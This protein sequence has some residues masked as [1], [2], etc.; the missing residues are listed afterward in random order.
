MLSMVAAASAQHVDDRPLGTNAQ[1]RGEILFENRCARCH[2][3]KGD[4]EGGL[5]PSLIGVIGKPVASRTD[6]IY[7]DALKA[8][9]R[10][11][12]PKVLDDYLADPQAFA[13]GAD[14]DI[15]SP[16]PAERAAIIEFVGTL[17]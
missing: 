8:K 1:P 7:S 15:R 11:W 13:P 12:A 5:G 4:G 14:M 6:F 17:R 9:G 2:G 16:D 10:I 3:L